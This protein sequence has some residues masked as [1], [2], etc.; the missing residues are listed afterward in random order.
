VSRL[1]CTAGGQ[2]QNQRHA[3]FLIQSAPQNVLVSIRQERRQ[4][5]PRP[6]AS[7]TLLAVSMSGDTVALDH[8]AVRSRQ[9]VDP[10]ARPNIDLSWRYLLIR[11]SSAA[12]APR[13][14]MVVYGAR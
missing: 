12:P 4:S 13:S 9:V 3:F 7:V 8:S 11:P 14:R 10:I 6:L 2:T 1:P 5:G